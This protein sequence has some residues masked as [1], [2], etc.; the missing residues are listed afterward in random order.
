MRE[1]LGVVVEAAIV[2]HRRI[3]RPLAGMAE[4]RVAEI[5][6][7]RQRL[8]QVLVEPERARQ[9]AGD[10]R[11]LERM[12]QAGAVV[13]ALIDKKTWV[14]SLSRRK[15]VEWMMRSRSRW[16]SVRVGLGGSW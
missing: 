16:N 3:E 5:V 15:A 11:H 8:G 9:R 2:R 10:L 14:L 12:G 13:I 4:G 1:A 7:E 6:G